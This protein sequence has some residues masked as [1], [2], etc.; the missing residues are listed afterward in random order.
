MRNEMRRDAPGAF[1]GKA[2][3]CLNR[4]NAAQV[5]RRGQYSPI[6]EASAGQSVSIDGLKEG[7]HGDHGLLIGVF[8]EA[9]GK[10]RTGLGPRILAK[11]GKLVRR[12]LDGAVANHRA[13][14]R[15]VG[16]L[17]VRP[18]TLCAALIACAALTTEPVS[19]WLHA[20]RILSRRQPRSRPC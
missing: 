5:A 3:Q 20:T 14:N 4:G 19:D 1:R 8:E 17:L 18:L 10:W 13:A 11:A 2:L 6:G 9:W 12:G 7:G 15:M 16:G